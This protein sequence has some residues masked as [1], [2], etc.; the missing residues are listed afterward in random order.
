MLTAT[1]TDVTAD[2]SSAVYGQAVTPTATVA[3]AG[4][5]SAGPTGT[6][7]FVDQS[8]GQDLG[9]AGLAWNASQGA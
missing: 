9:T 1:T 7:N 6:V 4:P 3:V 8:T 5:T 2:L